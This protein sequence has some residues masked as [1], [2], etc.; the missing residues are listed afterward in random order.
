M[1]CSRMRHP[2]KGH[3]GK[4]AARAFKLQIYLDT[5]W[6][7]ERTIRTRPGSGRWEIGYVP[8]PP[9]IASPQVR[10]VFQEDKRHSPTMCSCRLSFLEALPR[11]RTKVPRPIQGIYAGS[12]IEYRYPSLQLFT[13]PFVE[14]LLGPSW[15]EIGA[16]WAE[17]GT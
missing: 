6:D 14:A 4:D 11:T 3:D 12:L 2:S 7:G 15:L 9:W 8:K 17:S 16:S 1:S 13:Q 10:S 5:Q